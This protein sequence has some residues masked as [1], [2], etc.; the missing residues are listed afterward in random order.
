MRVASG[1]LTVRRLARQ[2]GVSQPHMHNIMKGKRSLTIELADRLLQFQHLSVLDLA[3]ASELGEALKLAAD[4]T[5]S[6]RHVPILPGVL[7]PAHPFPELDACADWV[8]LPPHSVAHAVV[9][10]FVELGS[11]AYLER[12]FPGASFALI[13]TFAEG[14]ACVD[15]RRWYALRW[16]GG[17]WIRRLRVGQG[18]LFVLGQEGLRPSL[19]PDAI[20]L[21]DSKIEEHVR[22]LV[23]W[24]GGD[25]RLA[26]PLR[27]SG[28]LVPPPAT[29]S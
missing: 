29:A 20:D 24:M 6:V 8:A 2:I 9:P 4:N 16:S 23:V 10:A 25:P 19:G 7:G 26:N 22:G 15:Q 3:K 18:R 1:S 21:T 12:E 27:E 13:D 28:Y 5:A 11:D 14:Q 17:G